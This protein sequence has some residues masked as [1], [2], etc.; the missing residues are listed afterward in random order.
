MNHS[1]AA[2]RLEPKSLDLETQKHKYGTEAEI[3]GGN[4]EN[5]CR[6]QTKTTIRRTI[7]SW[8][9]LI[10]IGPSLAAGVGYLLSKH[11]QR[12]AG[13]YSSANTKSDLVKTTI[14]P[15]APEDHLTQATPKIPRMPPGHPKPPV[16]SA[17]D[18]KAPP[19]QPDAGKTQE[20]L[21][22]EIAATTS[23][24]APT[25]KTIAAPPAV[26][27]P[28]TPTTVQTAT[29]N[30]GYDAKAAAQPVS[31]PAPQPATLVPTAPGDPDAPPPPNLINNRVVLDPAP[32]YAVYRITKTPTGTAAGI[33]VTNSVTIYDRWAVACE[34]RL[35]DK[36]CFA[37][38]YL[39]ANGT[40]MKVKIGAAAPVNETS[41]PSS[42]LRDSENRPRY[43][44]TIEGPAG[45]DQ[46][47]GLSITGNNAFGII[48]LTGQCSATQCVASAFII[49]E[50]GTLTRDLS[51]GDETISITGTV[52]NQGYVWK[53]DGSGLNAAFARVM[54]E[55]GDPRPT[56]IIGSA[57]SA[58][59]DGLT[60]LQS[61]ALRH[62][63]N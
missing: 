41:G 21:A 37:S 46:D 39:Q 3:A 27:E 20:Q 57:I 63:S 48:P 43:V 26:S 34:S 19:T 9:L 40:I 33:P 24:I 45:F 54:L 6:T 52:G 7:A 23:S 29:P 50:Y 49:P 4:S 36:S 12:T 62:A 51:N 1:T 60:T 56:S 28:A 10:V 55:M 53:F 44:V 47:V 13:Y 5:E 42:I 15:P 18:Q 38:A 58:E 61:Y 22:E 17:T 59:G 8:S 35:T 14:S 11:Q 31:Q 16:A 30:S 32:G 2:H 25:T